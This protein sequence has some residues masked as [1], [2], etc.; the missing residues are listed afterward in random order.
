MMVLS[1]L[2]KKE[3]FAFIEQLKIS[4]KKKINGLLSCLINVIISFSHSSF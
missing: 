3:T 1:I 4:V 2:Q